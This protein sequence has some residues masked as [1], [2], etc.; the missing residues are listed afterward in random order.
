MISPAMNNARL[1]SLIREHGT[2]D[3]GQPGYWKFEYRERAVLT[4][5]DEARD[6]MRIITPV[7]EVTDLS[8]EIW[9]LALTAN[10][11]RA[12]DARYAINGDYLWSAFIH[13]LGS[14]TDEQFVDGLQQVTTLADNFGTTFA[15]SSLIFG[16]SA[17]PD[18]H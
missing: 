16:G 1:D 6:R 12:L 8:E 10:F 4:L 17:E 2:V 7:A 13:P 5:T 3:E 14:L 11:D 18:S 9:L 15:S